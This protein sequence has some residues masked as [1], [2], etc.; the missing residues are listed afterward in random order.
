MPKSTGALMQRITAS[1]E[2]LHQLASLFPYLF[3]TFLISENEDQTID[4]F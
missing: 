1:Q 4:E 2:A 3:L